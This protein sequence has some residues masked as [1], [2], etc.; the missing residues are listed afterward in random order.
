M[1]DIC[2]E[3]LALKSLKYS[4]FLFCF[5]SATLNL[6]VFGGAAG[7]ADVGADSNLKLHS[8]AKIAVLLASRLLAATS[9]AAAAVGTGRATAQHQLVRVWGL[10]S[11]QSLPPHEQ[12]L[13]QKLARTTVLPGLAKIIYILCVPAGIYEQRSAYIGY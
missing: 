4:Y 1:T 12:P 5:V 13:R 7:A 9:T 10:E 3:R 6:P 2:T 11:A 8:L